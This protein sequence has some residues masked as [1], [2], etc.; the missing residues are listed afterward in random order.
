MSAV[1][2]EGQ[3]HGALNLQAGL[4]TVFHGSGLDASV[5]RRLYVGH[6]LA[7]WGAR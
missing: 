1:I 2:G 3:S 4:D 7:R 6:F 5:L